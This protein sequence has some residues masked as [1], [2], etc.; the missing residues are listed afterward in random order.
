MSAMFHKAP[1]TGVFASHEDKPQDQKEEEEGDSL[2]TILRT[3]EERSALTLLVANCTESMRR[4][5]NDTFDARQT[6]KKSDMTTDLK[7]PEAST[8]GRAH[9]GTVNVAQQDKLK[10]ELEQRERELGGPKMRELKEAAL[11]FFDTWRDSVLS[12]VGEILNSKEQAL[13][14]RDRAKPEP[15]S[16]KK[17]ANPRQLPKPPQYDAGVGEMMRQ[18]YP[19]MKTPLQNLAE[20]KRALI[21]HSVFLLLLSLEHYQSYSRTLLLYLSNSLDLDV[22]FLT[23]DESKVARGLLTAAENMRADEETK[24]KAEANH[25]NRKWKVGLATVAGAALIGVTGGLAAPLIA[26]GLGTM[27]GGLG[28]GATAAAG[29][30][31]TL[32]GSTVLVGGLFGAYGGRMTGKMIDQYAR[33]VEDFAFIPVRNHSKPRK[34]E[35][36]YRRLRV[37]IGISGWLTGKDDIV[38]PWKVIGTEMETFALRWELEALMNLGN[39]MSI[40]VTSAAWGY[41]KGEIIK[42]TVFAS[43][44]AGLWPLGLLKIGRIIDNPWSV[45]SYRAQ[46]AGEVLADALINKA[47]G[48]R[49]VTLIGYSLGARVIYTCLQSLAERKAFGLI[50]SVVLIGAPTPS[51]SADWRKIRTIVSG[52]VVNVFSVNDYILAFLYRSSSIQFGVAGLQAV[53]N[54]KGVENVDVSDLVTGHTSYRFLT[55]T[56]LQKIGFEDVDAYELEKEQAERKAEEAKQAQELKKS[57]KHVEASQPP[58]QAMGDTKLDEAPSTVKNALPGSTSTPEVSEQQVDEMQAEIEKKNQQSFMGHAQEQLMSAGT[59]ASAAYEK[60]KLQWKMRSQGSGV[61][62]GAAAASAGA[63]TPGEGD[64]GYQA[65]KARSKARKAGSSE[66]PRGPLM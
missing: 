12:R 44:T 2:T 21:L 9:P 10:R 3:A 41:A 28:L 66:M 53:E 62:K 24:K 65:I 64:E 5:I 31:G 58:T 56:I 26:A 1:W 23:Q 19:A 35:K 46:K 16:P 18:L 40:M 6:G 25:D 57:E 14:Q 50:E 39:S 4:S 33:E 63:D 52:R 32:A 55:G 45:A 11:N 7:G 37:A 49:P 13:H 34:I 36:E 48:E 27:M 8:D 60:A 17:S 51:T 15:A 42:R 61:G 29:Y 38:E 54:V 59:S 22:S 43:L 20:E 30:L 47:Q